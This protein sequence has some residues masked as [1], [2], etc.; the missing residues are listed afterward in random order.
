MITLTVA[1]VLPN[2]ARWEVDDWEPHEK[3]GWGMATIALRSPGATDYTVVKTI[4][5]RD[6][7][8]M[9]GASDKIGYLA[10]VGRE[11]HDFLTVTPRGLVNATGF[12]QCHNAYQNAAGGRAARLNALASFLLTIGI[13]DSTLAGA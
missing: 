11:I 13:A 7:T 10:I 2:L 5:V 9:G 12:T 8:V 4:I 1:K 3:A 6:A